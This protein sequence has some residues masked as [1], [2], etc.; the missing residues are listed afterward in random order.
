MQQVGGS[1]G[2]ALLNTIAATT[3]TAYIRGKLP[4]PTLLAQ[5]RIE[6]FVTAFWWVTEIFLVSGAVLVALLPNKLNTSTEVD[7][8]AAL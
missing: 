8:L 3:A 2:T 1:I 6:G 5:A 7:T 4:G